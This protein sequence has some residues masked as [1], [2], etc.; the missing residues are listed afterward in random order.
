MTLDEF[1][2]KYDGVGVDTDGAYGFQC[3]DLMHR[4]VIDVLHQA[5]PGI[6]RAADART[7]FRSFPSITGSEL[8]D[9][10]NNTPTN[11]PQKGDIMFWDY[12]PSG[13]VAIFLEGDASTF[14]SFD[15]NFPTGSKC[16]RQVHN[17]SSVLGWLRFKSQQPSTGGTVS[18]TPTVLVSDVIKACWRAIT[19]FEASDFDVKTELSKPFVLEDLIK[20][21][22]NAA[23]YHTKV[24]Y[25]AVQQ[26]LKEA[27]DEI[28]TLKDQTSNGGV[29]SP[30][31]QPNP[32]SGETPVPPTSD[33][34]NGPSSGNVL[35]QAF[36]SILKWLKT[37]WPKL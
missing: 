2:R 18:M 15:Q 6:L 23:G 14:T 30:L 3:M 33:L 29:G 36:T 8:F 7:V 27:N 24:E 31:P 1:I 12:N 4:Y 17:Y 10:I 13:H 11:V 32:P 28:Q 37:I 26:A 34:P 16:H 20:R 35:E 5:D 9:K 25:D 22:I 21:L 19:G